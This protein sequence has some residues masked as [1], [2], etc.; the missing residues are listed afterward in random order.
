MKQL[1]TFAVLPGQ[2]RQHT[3][4]NVLIFYVVVI[5]NLGPPKMETAKKRGTLS[6]KCTAE[7]SHYHPQISWNVGRD[8]EIPGKFNCTLYYVKM[9]LYIEE[10][11]WWFHFKTQF[12]FKTVV[13]FNVP[14]V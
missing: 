14:D 8:S 3:F 2:N 13:S 12:N 11:L 4:C 1:S 5:N 10:N 7:A 9:I 6:V